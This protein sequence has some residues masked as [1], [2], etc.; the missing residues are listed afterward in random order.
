MNANYVCQ[1]GVH[2]AALPVV[3]PSSQLS[4]IDYFPDPEP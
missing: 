1:H 4:D 2:R 3:D